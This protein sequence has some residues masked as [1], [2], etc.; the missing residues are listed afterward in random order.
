[1]ENVMR[2][3]PPTMERVERL[4]PAMETHLRVTRQIDRFAQLELRASESRQPKPAQDDDLPTA[5]EEPPEDAP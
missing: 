4:L 3:G 2:S 5:P 1:M